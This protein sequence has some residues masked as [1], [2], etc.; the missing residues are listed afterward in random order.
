[1]TAALIPMARKR[2]TFKLDEHL[3]EQ[4]KVA[5][6]RDN[7]SANNWV[8]TLLLEA[9][10]KSGVVEEDY[11]PRQENRGGLRVKETTSEAPADD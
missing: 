4:L 5:A 10:K 3:L 6:Y 7:T 1:M 2:K 11:Y 8:E 9:L